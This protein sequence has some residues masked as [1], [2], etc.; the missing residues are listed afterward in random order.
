MAYYGSVTLF[1]SGRSR[2]DGEG[3]GSK[4]KRRRGEYD[5]DENSCADTE[6]K[7]PKLCVCVWA[8][9][10]AGAGGRLDRRQPRSTAA[11]DRDQHHEAHRHHRCH[12]HR[13]HHPVGPG[14]VLTYGQFPPK[15][16]PTHHPRYLKLRKED[17]ERNAY[18]GGGGRVGRAGWGGRGGVGWSG[19]GRG[20][21]REPPSPPPPP[22]PPSYNIDDLWVLAPAS[23]EFG[24]RLSKTPGAPSRIYFLHSLWRSPTSGAEPMMECRE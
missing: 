5:D 1:M 3:W 24:A 2:E 18:V 8:A 17:L 10:V 11:T 6:R 13:R 4:K 16:T 15:P 14:T 12:R 20:G 22:P 9:R 7:E 23:V 19:R 21:P